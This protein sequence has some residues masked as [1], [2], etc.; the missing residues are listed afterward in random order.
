MDPL[1]AIALAGNILQ[2]VETSVT[3][4]SKSRELYRSSDGSLVE[5]S[6]SERITKDL[7][8][9]SRKIK[10]SSGNADP[11]IKNLCDECEAISG[12]LLKVLSK[13]QVKGKHRKSES[14]RIAI[15]SALGID[16]VESLGR[17][18]AQYREQLVLHVSMRN[19]CD[20]N[21]YLFI[22]A[23]MLKYTVSKF[24]LLPT[25]NLMRSRAL[26]LLHNQTSI[27]YSRHYKTTD[28]RYRKTYLLRQGIWSLS[29]FKRSTTSKTQHK[30]PKG[31]CRCITIASCSQ[32][33]A[34]IAIQGPL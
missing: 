15:R 29:S 32:L 21:P 30:R 5:N 22:P 1:T 34:K 27:R 4:I 13:L 11:E 17:R 24:S 20:A 26:M 25:G 8:A 23:M 18:L 12:E 19:G 2:F 31:S 3:V 14:L 9:L 28:R 7:E 6:D 10:Q 33:L 16:E